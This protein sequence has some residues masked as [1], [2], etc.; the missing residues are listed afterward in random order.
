M[1]SPKGSNLSRFGNQKP[2]EASSGE[3]A[4]RP[5]ETPKVDTR[6]GRTVRFTPAQWRTVRNLETN[7][8]ITF[9]DLCIEGISLILERHGLGPL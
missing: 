7:L 5:P 6:I 4:L 3:D 1:P 2:Q 9:Q 8:N